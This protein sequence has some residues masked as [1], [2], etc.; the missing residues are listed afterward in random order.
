MKTVKDWKLVQKRG[1]GRPK[2][3]DN[4]YELFNILIASGNSERFLDSTI[5]FHGLLLLIIDSDV[6]EL[7]SNDKFKFQLLSALEQAHEQ[8]L[9]F[10]DGKEY[11]KFEIGFSSD[12]TLYGIYTY[13]MLKKISQCWRR[14]SPQTIMD[15]MPDPSWYNEWLK[16]YK[17]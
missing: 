12:R 5:Y 8:I 2:A 11:P 15:A 16:Y 17:F 1:S 3:F 10:F 9:D 7:L 6:I 13:N 14:N 4:I